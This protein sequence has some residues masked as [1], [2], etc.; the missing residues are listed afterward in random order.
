MQD[1]FVALY[2]LSESL[3]KM[4]KREETYLGGHG[5]M[6]REGERGYK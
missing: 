3:N 2:Q 6:A 1:G 5:E 4:Y